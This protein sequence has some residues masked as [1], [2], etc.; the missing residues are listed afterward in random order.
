LLAIGGIKRAQVAIGEAA[1]VGKLSAMTVTILQR[2]CRAQMPDPLSLS[3]S[4]FREDVDGCRCRRQAGDLEVGV[5]FAEYL[6]EF[7]ERI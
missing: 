7:T 5:G 3:L 2:A 6:F 4:V 1:L